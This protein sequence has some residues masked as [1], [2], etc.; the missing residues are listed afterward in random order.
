M[1]VYDSA[2]TELIPVT[3]DY[4]STGNL[5]LRNTGEPRYLR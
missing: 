5:L 2:G 3:G 4:S 1:V